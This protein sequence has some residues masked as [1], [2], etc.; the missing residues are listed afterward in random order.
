MAFVVTDTAAEGVKII[1]DDD[2]VVIAT[3]VEHRSPIEGLALQ[4]A[5]APDLLDA[6]QGLIPDF[7][8]GIDPIE[9]D[10]VVKAR[11]AIARATGEQP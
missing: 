3:V 1:S 4:M 10:A 8:G 7:T 5:A 11:A 2:R 9:A 6:L